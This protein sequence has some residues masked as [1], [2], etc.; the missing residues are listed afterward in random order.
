MPPKRLGIPQLMAEMGE[1]VLHLQKMLSQLYD[2]KR[3]K[4]KL[5]KFHYRYAVI[6]TPILSFAF[7]FMIL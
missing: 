6:S 1:R 5:P 4:G 7:Y 2:R 3:I